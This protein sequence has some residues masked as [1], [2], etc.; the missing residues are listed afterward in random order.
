[1]ILLFMIVR[2]LS[3]RFHHHTSKLA[4]QVYYL[5]SSQNKKIS[6]KFKNRHHLTLL[7][8]VKCD[9]TARK[10]MTFAKQ[11]NSLSMQKKK[12]LS[13]ALYEPLE[14]SFWRKMGPVEHG[15]NHQPCEESPKELETSKLKLKE[16]EGES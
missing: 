2:P 1:M 8:N 7:T 4:I 9:L 5:L 6:V 3:L 14:S 10:N 11:I 12:L 13:E 15:M 16:V